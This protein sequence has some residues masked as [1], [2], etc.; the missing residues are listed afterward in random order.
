MNRRVQLV[1]YDHRILVSTFI[2]HLK[3]LGNQLQQNIDER[4]NDHPSYKHVT[5]LSYF[6]PFLQQL[7]QVRHIVQSS[8]KAS[9][10]YKM[11]VKQ[12]RQTS[13][14]CVL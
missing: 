3:Y 9:V 13:S 1:T 12:Y 7:S 4:I 8:I 5:T 11:K 14:N 6:K 10:N 2:L